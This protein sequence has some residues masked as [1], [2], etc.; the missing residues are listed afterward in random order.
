MQLNRIHK[1]KR[2]HIP[3]FSSAIFDTKSKNYS[4]KPNDCQN[5]GLR[6]EHVVKEN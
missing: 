1:I 3:F 6:L 4:Q 2:D 5:H